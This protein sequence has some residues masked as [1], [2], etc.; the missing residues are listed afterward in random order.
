MLTPIGTLVVVG[1]TIGTLVVV[2]K[3]FKKPPPFLWSI[4]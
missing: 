3:T 1:K 4:Q 2:G